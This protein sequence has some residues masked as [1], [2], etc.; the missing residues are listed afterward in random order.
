MG[1]GDLVSGRKALIDNAELMAE[2]TCAGAR[3][4][5]LQMFAASCH[6]AAVTAIEAP[7]GV[8]SSAIVK[9]FRE[10]FNAVIANGQGEMK[11]QL[12][13]MAHIGFYD[14]LDT[15]GI[16]AALEQVLAHVTGKPVEYG[17]AV[18]AAQAVFAK[19]TE[20]AASR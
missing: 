18:R 8:D 6:S 7:K 12:F 15:I 3:A 5:G 4:L 13:R 20:A 9:E 17:S 14:Y 1:Q 10:S 11:G 2:M 16:L 19:Q